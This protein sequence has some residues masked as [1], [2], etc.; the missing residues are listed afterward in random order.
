MLPSLLAML[1]NGTITDTNPS[2][3]LILEEA[4][5]GIRTPGHGLSPFSTAGTAAHDLG[6]HSV[7]SVQSS[8]EGNG[9]I[10][11]WCSSESSAEANV[12]C[13]LCGRIFLE[14][15][16]LLANPRT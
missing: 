14:I 4:M 11:T 6:G 2:Q 7:V 16:S 15:E 13:I 5:L 10:C 8:T 3:I 9:N 12:T 1:A